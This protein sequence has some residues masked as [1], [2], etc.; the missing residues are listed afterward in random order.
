MTATLPHCSRGE[1]WFLDWNPRRGSEQEGVRP[2]LIVQTDLDNHAPG[3]RTTILV[4]LTSRGRAFVFY[5]SIPKSPANGLSED[6]WANCTQLLTVDKS[7]LVKRLGK[8]SAGQM[9]QVGEALR[10]TL[11]L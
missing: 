4:P 7:R 6:S 11:E 1:I 2:G 9:Q 8:V 10:A 3:A 5:V